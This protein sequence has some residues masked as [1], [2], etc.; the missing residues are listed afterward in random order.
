[1][2]PKVSII[3]A[4]YNRAHFIAES[5][6]SIQNQTFLDWECLIIDDGGTDHTTEIITP[7]LEQDSRFKYTK[8]SDHYLKGIP[9]CRNYGLDLAKGEFIIFFDDDDIA[10]PQNLELCVLELKD[11]AISFCRYV[12][13]VFVNDFNY[14]FDYSKTYTSFYIDKNDIERM[15]KNELQ[16]NSCAVM[17]KAVCFEAN[18]Y[19]EKLM[20]AEEW[21]LYSRIVSSGHRG[22]SINKTLFYGRKHMQSNTGEYDRKNAFRKASYAEAIVLVVKNLRE[23]QLLTYA[24][25]RYFMAFSIGFKEYDVFKK[26]LNILELPTFEKIKW[27]IFY[28]ILPLRLNIYRMNKALKKK[29]Q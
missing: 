7:I 11:P 5:L 19:I 24:L 6:L 20:F 17:W 9:G 2:N 29:R 13:E 25:K 4:T 14:Q 8:R 23:K 27:Q 28:A 10:H 26:I 15:L 22:I 3:M 1:M 21:E 12:R 16:F 18:R